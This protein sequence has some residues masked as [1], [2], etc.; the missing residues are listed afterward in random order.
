MPPKIEKNEELLAQMQDLVQTLVS[1]RLDTFKEQLAA[2]AAVKTDTHSPFSN[3]P[4]AQK[5]FLRSFDGSL[6]WTG[7]FK[8]TNT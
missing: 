3:Q 7:F 6:H 5:I 8:L 4:K 1:S 2:S